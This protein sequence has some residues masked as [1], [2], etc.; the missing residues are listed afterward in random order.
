MRRAAILALGAGTLLAGCAGPAYLTRAAWSEARILF[1][2]EPIAEI[3]EQPGLDP[4]RADRL[5]LA[6]AAREFARDTLGLRVGESYS[7]FVDVDETA[8]VHVVSAAYRD[9]LESHLWRYPFVGRLP[10]RGFFDRADADAAAARLTADGLDVEIRPA[11]AF[12]TLGWF[13]DPLLSS[14]AAEPPVALVE[15]IIHE[16]FHATVWRAGDIAFNESAANWMGHRGAIAFFCAGGP[17]ADET[18]CREARR[19]WAV[20]RARG[21]IFARL[22]ARLRKLYA[23]VPPPPAR[24][25]AR[26]RLAA[27]AGDQ[28]EARRLGSRSELSPPNNARLLGMQLYTTGLEDFERAVPPGGDLRAGLAALGIPV[29][30]GSP[31]P[32][33][34]SGGTAAGRL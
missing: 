27:W 21:R 14:T 4:V 3:L 33:Q 9:R 30:G 6:L 10:Y 25:R 20:T 28:L 19:R 8:P 16:L 1:R 12:S 18:R 2:R 11:T 31:R 26:T 13:A 5:R 32:R 23:A 29:E 24:E 22:A 7:T 15:T 17:G 34:P